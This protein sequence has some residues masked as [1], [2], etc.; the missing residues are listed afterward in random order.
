MRITLILLILSLSIPLFGQSKY[1]PRIPDAVIK[2]MIEKNTAEK[3]KNQA[4]TDAIRAQQKADKKKKKDNRKKLVA[5]TEGI[6]KPGTPASFNAPFHFDPIPQYLTG[7]CWCFSTTSFFESEIHRL[8]GQKVKLSEIFTV[9]YEYLAKAGRYIDERGDSFMGEGSESNAVT[10]IWKKY[11]I[12]PAEAYEGIV[13]DDKRHN[14][15]MM[16]DEIVAYLKFCKAQNFWEKEE[17]LKVISLILERYLGQPPAEFKYRGKTYTPASFLASLPL[18]LEDYYSV[19]STTSLP[20]FQKGKFDVPDNWWMNEDYYN[21]PLKDFYT[22][23]NRAL[24]N[25]QTLVIGGDVS[26]PGYYGEEDICFVPE[27]DIPSAHINQDSREFR[28]YNRTTQ[29]DHGIH[30]LARKTVGDDVWFLIKDSARSARKGK[31]K[32]Y[33]FYHSDYVKL[34]MLT[35][36]VHKEAIAPYLAKF[37]D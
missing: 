28:F 23:I 21:V 34:K 13:S 31:Y 32:G 33:L 5:V 7:T 18:K 27:F 26:E 29:D 15:E 25:G 17:I 22:I 11:G 12:V 36:T 2:E 20:F 10:R 30:L 16:F 6:V 1:V 9:Y 24:D 14:H 35:I 3:D 19:M 37:A 8:S 4:A